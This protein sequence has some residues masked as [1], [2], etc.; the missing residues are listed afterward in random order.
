[1]TLLA[2]GVTSPVTD[3]P[4]RSTDLNRVTRGDR[5]LPDGP[6]RGSWPQARRSPTSR[7]GAPHRRVGPWSGRTW[8]AGGQ[9]LAVHPRNLPIVAVDIERLHLVPIERCAV[10]ASGGRKLAVARTTAC[11]P[12]GASCTPEVARACEPPRRC[13][14]GLHPS[15]DG[16]PNRAPTLGRFG[17]PLDY[18]PFSRVSSQVRG[19]LPVRCRSTARTI[20]TRTV[21]VGNCRLTCV[22]DDWWSW[23]A[24]V[25]CEP[26]ADYA[27]TT[28][29]G[30]RWSVTDVFERVGGQIGPAS[31]DVVAGPFP[32]VPLRPLLP[33]SRCWIR[34]GGQASPGGSPFARV[35]AWRRR[36]P[37]RSV[38]ESVTLAARRARL[39]SSGFC[40]DGHSRRYA[41][42]RT[43]ADLGEAVRGERGV[44]ALWNSA[45]GGVGAPARKPR[46]IIDPRL[47]D[48][49]AGCHQRCA[50]GCP[51]RTL[52]AD[53]R[54][55]STPPRSRGGTSPHGIP[56][57][58]GRAI[59]A[60]APRAGGRR[61]RLPVRRRVLPRPS[62]RIGGLLS[63]RC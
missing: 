27:R 32:E 54:A 62:G 46:H 30:V 6:G 22:D 31:G 10:A 5:T 39:T 61:L 23:L 49:S 48:R 47:L 58:T 7:Q 16:A 28:G 18:G 3:R 24:L 57:R 50:E 44:S 41:A 20:P 55:A 45:R 40:L 11:G 36:L 2:Q 15:L 29:F 25:V 9:L 56:C 13:D 37:P 1:M 38:S 4:L 26:A 14:W 34:Q 59:S 51:C 35:P 17:L 53:A 21:G 33:P 8:P 63:R 42:P 12:G 19:T 52:R 60:I 43:A